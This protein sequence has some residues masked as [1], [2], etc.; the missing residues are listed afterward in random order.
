[1]ALEAEENQTESVQAAISTL[2]QEFEKYNDKVRQSTRSLA[3]HAREQ[4]GIWAGL[5]DGMRNFTNAL[6]NEYQI[7]VELAKGFGESAFRAINDPIEDFFLGQLKTFG[8]YWRNFCN[9]LV[10]LMSKAITQMLFEWLGFKRMMSTEEGSFWK[11]GLGA[12]LKAL[13]AGGGRGGAGIGYES[14][15]SPEGS[16]HQ[17]GTGADIM[18]RIPTMHSGG[19]GL[20]RD[21]A[22]VRMLKTE[23]ILNPRAMQA[24]G[25]QELDYRNRTGMVPAPNQFSASV[26]IVLNERNRKFEARLKTE[27]EATAV[28]V[29]KESV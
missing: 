23:G 12:L 25:K 9:D 22:L 14:W 18:A 1:L 8:D 7:G 2:R 24:M 13:F 29:M 3:Q 28:R 27:M 10:R 15:T 6:A 16:A 4:Q 5:E 21:E 17:G 26:Q 20:S 11:G 19:T